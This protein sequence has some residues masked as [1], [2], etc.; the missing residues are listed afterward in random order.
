MTPEKLNQL[1]EIKRQ[2]LERFPLESL[3]A[4]PLEVYTNLERSDS[5]CYWLESITYDL[6]SIWGG[7]AYKFYIFEYNQ[8]RNTEKKNGKYLRDG[9][10]TWLASL[11]DNRDSVYDEVLSRIVRIAS[12]ANSGNFSEIDDIAFGD[13]VK[14]KIAYLYSKD[15]L[16]PIYSREMLERFAS[17]YGM[18]DTKSRKISELQKFLVEKKGVEDGIA[19][20]HRVCRSDNPDVALHSSTVKYWILSPGSNASKWERCL[21]EGIACI[22]WEEL[23]DLNEYS[24]LEEMRSAMK[25]QYG[26]ASSNYKNAG[27]A[28]WEF[29]HE[30]QIGDIIFAKQGRNHIIGRGVVESD[31]YFDDSFP[32][33]NNVRRVRWEK[34]GDWTTLEPTALKTLTELTRY[35]DYV[36]KL[37]LLVEGKIANDDVVSYYWL[38]ANPKIWSIDDIKIGEVQTY[39][40]INE[41]GHKRRIYKYFSEIKP[42]DQ[43]V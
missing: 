24:S 31:Y 20:M 36:K 10:Y 9:K 3:H 29:C 14:W 26:N 11:G 43:I 8:S 19:F 16:V 30:I 40:A 22:G 42:G 39:E 33:F 27:L 18:P 13:V 28:T 21:K 23:G 15:R 7:S 37:G 32:D 41:N 5:F 34:T 4:M 12:A 17:E 38:N 35:P 6:G 25:E 1:H 2:F